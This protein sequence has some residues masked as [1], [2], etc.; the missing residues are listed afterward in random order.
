MSDADWIRVRAM[1]RTFQPCHGYFDDPADSHVE[2][3]DDGIAVIVQRD[4]LIK[5]YD[6]GMG[7]NAPPNAALLEF[8]C[9]VAGWTETT[10]GA[11]P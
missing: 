10:Q 11:T 8:W 6:M 4:G 9:R 1:V 7:T 3:R 2:L 5:R